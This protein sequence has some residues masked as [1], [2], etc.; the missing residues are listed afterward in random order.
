M[1]TASGLRNAV[2]RR[3]HSMQ[4]QLQREL[5]GQVEGGTQFGIG[6]IAG[7]WECRSTPEH[8]EADIVNVRPCV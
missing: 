6:P 2:R 3:H 8:V 1:A 5:L 4:E 7:H